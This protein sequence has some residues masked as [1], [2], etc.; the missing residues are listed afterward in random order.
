MIERALDTLVTTRSE[1]LQS[2]GSDACLV[3]IYPTGPAMGKRFPLGIS[4]LYLGRGEDN[5]IRIQ[6]SSVSRKHA[7]VHPVSDG[8]QVEDLGSTNGTFINDL[9][10]DRPTTLRDRSYLRVGNC[11]YKFLT[12]GNI[13]AD[14]HE[15]IYRLTITDGLTEINNHRFLIDYLDRELARSI[16]HE[17]PLAVVMFDLDKFKSVNDTH[18]HLCGDYVLR[19]LSQRIKKFVRREDLFARYGGEEFAVVLVETGMPMAIEAAERIRRTV[20]ET[21][22]RFDGAVLNLTVSLGV[23]STAGGEHGLTPLELLRRADALLYRAKQ[24][25]RNRAVSS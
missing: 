20:Y 21:P 7:V 12:G 18:G 8:F 2:G 19:E 24:A 1:L 3:H 16:R 25:G 17:R 9:P 5:D 23:A 13:E 15:E 4:S 11:I 22:F 6:D 10:V 14:Y